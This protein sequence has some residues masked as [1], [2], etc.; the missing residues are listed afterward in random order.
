MKRYPTLMSMKFAIWIC[1]A[2]ILFQAGCKN[3]PIDSPIKNP[4]EY[5]WTIDTLAYPGS[6][7]TLM[8]AI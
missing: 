1:T 3:N 7:Q 4:R 6:Y 5:T 8:Y 2:L